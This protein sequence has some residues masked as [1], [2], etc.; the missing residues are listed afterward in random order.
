MK[1]TFTSSAMTV[2]AALVLAAALLLI[3]AGCNVS[4]ANL[5]DV[6]ICDKLDNGQ[7]TSDM[8]SLDK[9]TPTLYVSANLNNAPTGTKIKVDWRYLGGDPGTEPQDIDSITLTSEEDSANLQ[10]S[11]DSGTGT[12]PIGD[13]E[14]VLKIDTD[15]ADP[16]HKTFSI[17]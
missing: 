4:T 12:F 5:S 2:T 10:S 1:K 14:V 3:S 11:L 15:N 16:I 8:S 13:Y 17:K 9:N 7:C 6:R